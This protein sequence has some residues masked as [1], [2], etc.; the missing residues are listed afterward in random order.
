MKKFLRNILTITAAALL[1]G[2]FVSCGEGEDEDSSQPGVLDIPKDY[3]PSEYTDEVPADL[4]D[5]AEII[6][7]LA[8]VTTDWG[9]DINIKKDFASRIQLESKVIFTI[10]KN[11]D[12][13]K[14][15][16][17]SGWS[18]CNTEV[19][20]DAKGESI[21][22]REN[23]DNPGVYETL[24][25]LEPGTYYFI[26]TEDNI[27]ILKS[28]FGIRG[29]FVLKKIGITNLRGE[30]EKEPEPDDLIELVKPADKDGYKTFWAQSSGAGEGSVMFILNY[31]SKTLD[32]AVTLSDVDIEYIIND[33]EAKHYTDDISIPKNEWGSD[34]QAKVALFADYKVTKNDAIYI[35]ITAKVNDEKAVSIIQGNLIDTD[36]SVNYWKEMCPENQQKQLMPGITYGE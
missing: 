25:G 17:A 31:E 18:D 13:A 24:D 3:N 15:M 29:H 21:P 12:Y 4:W 34:Y 32:K 5:G 11:G 19:Y 26:V 2:S 16:V 9:E 23:A 30:N 14:F 6:E 35:K 36:P 8:G 20:Y 10:D 28:A 7:D 27:D 22:V 1:L 33:G